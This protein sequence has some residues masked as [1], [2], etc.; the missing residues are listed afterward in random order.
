[1]KN[2]LA[3][4]AVV[5]LFMAVVPAFGEIRGNDVLDSCQIAV[6]NF[7]DN[8]G[9]AGERFDAGW[10][11][12]WV[13]GALE[14][15]KLHNER[16]TLIKEKPTLLQFCVGVPGIPVIQAMRIVVKYLKEHPEQLHEDGMGLTVTALKDA[17]PCK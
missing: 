8:G 7:D 10:C 6:R 9:P 13:N 5:F 2:W 15:T 1:V 3:P 17:F 16:T 11:S 12:G 14:L 4:I